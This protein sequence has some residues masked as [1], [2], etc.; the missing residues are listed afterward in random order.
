MKY[1]LADYILSI[2]PDDSRLSAFGTLNIGGEGTAIGSISIAYDNSMWSTTSFATGGWVHDKNLSRTGTIS[3]QIS[4]LSDKVSK[5]MQ[6]ANIFYSGDYDGFTIT[7]SDSLGQQ[8]ATCVDCYFKQIPS[9]EF[10][11]SAANQTWSLTSGKITF[12]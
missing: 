10:G 1:S 11:D 2:R 7:L 5:M 9:Q 4:Q 12:S 8:I 3:I 6:F